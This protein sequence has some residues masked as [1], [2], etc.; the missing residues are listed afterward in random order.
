MGGGS[1]GAV[2]ATRLSKNNRVLLLEAGGDPLFYN[3]I[4][5]L[6]P[7]MLH[8]PELD[9]GYKTVPQKLSN[10]A[11]VDQVSLILL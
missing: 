11:M 8:K 3:S 1:S 9:W 5:I 4:P 2:V 7:E 6:A 10:L